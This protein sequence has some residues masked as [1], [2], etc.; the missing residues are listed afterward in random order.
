MDLVRDVLDEQLIDARGRNAGKVDGI[1]LELRPDRPPRVVAIE[2]GGG[3]AA[4]RMP[5]L[6]RGPMMA[7]SRLLLPRGR[8]ARRIPWS[9]LH[10]GARDIRIDAGR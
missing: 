4:E 5:R 6:L 1:V 3:T 10:F 2:I 7:L 9:R 8:R